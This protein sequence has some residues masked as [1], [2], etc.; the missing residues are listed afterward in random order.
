MIVLSLLM[1]HFA[2]RQEELADFS[3]NISFY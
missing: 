2:G 1:S 3:T